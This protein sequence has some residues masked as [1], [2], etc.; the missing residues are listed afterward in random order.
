MGR[1]SIVID[2]DELTRE[3]RIREADAVSLQDLFTKVAESSWGRTRVNSVGAVVSPSWATFY[4]KAKALGI[5]INMKEREQSSNPFAGSK[6]KGPRTKKT[7]PIESIQQYNRLFPKNEKLINRM[8]KGSRSAG[9]RLMCID[10][11]GSAAEARKCDLT[12]CPLYYFSPY[13]QKDR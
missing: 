4:N 9:I 6:P 7:I 13:T 8:C 3:I 10:C 11:C 5:P 12:K 1:A 2:G